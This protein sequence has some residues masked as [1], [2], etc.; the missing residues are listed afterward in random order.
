VI[1]SDY[2]PSES[3]QRGYKPGYDGSFKIID[4]LVWTDLYAMNIDSGSQTF[5]DYWA[6][7]GEHPGAVY[8]GATTG[9]KRRDWREM[10]EREGHVEGG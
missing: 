8:V 10:K 5:Q 1:E 3:K 2:D 9:V 7:A 6:L 4:Q